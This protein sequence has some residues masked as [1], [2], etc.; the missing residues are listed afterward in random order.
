[1]AGLP[2]WKNSQ[3]AINYWEPVFQNQ[4]L[5]TITPPAPAS[6]GNST[7]LLVEHVVS[8]D[9]IPE[10]LPATVEQRYKFAQRSFS[11][12]RPENTIADLTIKFTVNLNTTNDMYIYNA[13]RAW[14]DLHYNPLNGR[15]GL[16]RFQVGSIA[17]QMQNK[18]AETFRT[19]NF[20][21]C[22]M[23]GPLSAIKLDYTATELYE[24]TAKWRAD[25]WNETRVGQITTAG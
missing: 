8:V 18:A 23:N 4:F 13:L 3:A 1:M 17:I 10:I 20:N 7:A 16:K 19:F 22:I 24:I 2:H 14:A 25:S 21:P 12:S 9:G 15:Q 11:A 5:I 6:S